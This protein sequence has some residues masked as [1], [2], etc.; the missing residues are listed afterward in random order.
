MGTG[1]KLNPMGFQVAD[2]F[3]TEMDALA[4]V[5]RKELRKRGIEHL[6]VVYSQEEA[7]TPLFAAE[8]DQEQTNNIKSPT[9]PKQTPGSL[10][11]VPAAAGL[12]IA[13]EVVKDL[14]E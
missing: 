8:V 9:R 10:A 5:M 13:A 11:F 2:I 6:K 12:L 4:R 14:T 1:N 3:D 7:I